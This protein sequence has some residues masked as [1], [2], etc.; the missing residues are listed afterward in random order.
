L[1][2]IKF[3]AWDKEESKMIYEVEKTYDHGCHGY[4][5]MESNF[6][7]VLEN[8]IYEV[9]Q[10]TG[11]RDKNGKEIYEGDILSDGEYNYRVDFYKGEFSLTYRNSYYTIC[12]TAN[13]LD[14]VGNIYG[15]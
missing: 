10:F 7:E 15:G 13:N 11:L 8:G 9:M 3:R 1:R 2:E 12:P 14:I 6:G 5:A 4:G